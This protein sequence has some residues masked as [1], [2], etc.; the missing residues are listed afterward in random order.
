MTKVKKLIAL[1]L[2]VCIAA[3]VGIVSVSAA[4]VDDAESVQAKFDGIK[5]HVYSEDGIMLYSVHIFLDG[6]KSKKKNKKKKV[7]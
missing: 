5:V 7:S 6:F 3:T 1:M 2:V 4:T